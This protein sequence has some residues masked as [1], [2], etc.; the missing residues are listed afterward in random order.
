MALIDL[1]EVPEQAETPVRKRPVPYRAV[2]GAVSLVLVALPAG[3][4][5]H[6]PPRPPAIIPA[7]LGDTT[8]LDGDRLFLVGSGA[9]ETGPQE[10]VQNRVV[11]SYRLPEARLTGR[12]T[13]AVAGA[14]TGVTQVGDVIVVGYQF[15]ADGSQGVVAQTAGA[16]SALWRRTARLVATSPA[17][18]I[19]L[20]AD[21]TGELAVDLRTGALRWQVPNSADGVLTEAGSQAG[22]YPRWLMLITDSG[23]LRTWDAHTGRPIASVV[24]PAVAGRATG[25]IW[26]I[27]D[28]ILV[29]V[30]AGY[31]AYRLPGLDRLWH[32]AADLSQSWMEID[33]GPVICTFQQQQGMTALD[34][35]TGAEVWR[36]DRWAYAEPYGPYLLSGAGAEDPSLFVIDPA[37]GRALGN[38]GDWQGLGPAGDGLLYG[39]TDEHGTYRIYYGLLDPATRRIDYLGRADRVSGDCAST[40]ETAPVLV[41]RLIDASYA[42]WPLR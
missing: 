30:G 40:G 8:Y 2:L 42:V 22:S 37:T 3:A 25:L 36:S 29:D 21:A 11:S 6:P 4:A 12:T 27:G 20:L 17:D 13:I 31:D 1:G 41:C 19:A 14:V 39:K 16:S 35:A 23:Q 26:P 34:P 24:V 32:T 33:C 9:Q 10:T 18:G 5:H 7:R 28:L 15:D 38:F